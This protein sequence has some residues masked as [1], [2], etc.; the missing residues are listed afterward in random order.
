MLEASTIGKIRR[1]RIEEEIDGREIKRGLSKCMY[2]YVVHVH[3]VYNNKKKYRWKVPHFPA[4]G[5]SRVQ[6]SPVTSRERER[7]P[8]PNTKSGLLFHLSVLCVYIYMYV[9]SSVHLRMWANIKRRSL[10]AIC[11]EHHRDGRVLSFSSSSFLA[12]GPDGIGL[13]V[14]K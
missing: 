14:G 9:R 2:V 13:Y 5:L 7:E 11:N 4:T 8:P 1:K 6:S 10:A 3:N 12:I